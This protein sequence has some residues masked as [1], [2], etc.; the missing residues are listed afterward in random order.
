MCLWASKEATHWLLKDLNNDKIKTIT[1]TK[2]YRFRIENNRVILS[3]PFRGDDITNFGKVESTRKIKDIDY[4]EYN[5]VVISEG[6]HCYGGK[7]DWLF[8]TRID[9]NVSSS[10]EMLFIPVSIETKDII[11]VSDMFVLGES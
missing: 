5:F 9:F 1:A 7:Q 8:T 6:I 3:A 10:Q 11:G 4:L 2:M